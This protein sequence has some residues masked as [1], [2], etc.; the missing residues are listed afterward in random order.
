V[1]SGEISDAESDPVFPPGLEGKR[2]DGIKA[3]FRMEAPKLVK[4]ETG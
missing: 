1:V 4:T 2:W 3:F